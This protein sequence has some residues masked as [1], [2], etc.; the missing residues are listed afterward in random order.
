MQRI[1]AERCRLNSNSNP[2]TLLL[3]DPA[4]AYYFIFVVED[5]SLAWGYGSLGVVEGGFYFAVIGHANCGRGWFVAV[6]NL[7]S[8]SH[9]AFE[10]R[11][12][13]PVEFA[14][15]ESLCGRFGVAADCDAMA[16]VIDLNDV[17]R[18]GRGYTEALALADG[19]VVDAGV[20][21]DHLAR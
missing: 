7:G 2:Q 3:D 8:D 14:G 12:G 11:D 6:T 1:G 19:E 15:A 18:V 13:N 20:A 10:M 17:E 16:G 5:G 9:L 4:A 21:A